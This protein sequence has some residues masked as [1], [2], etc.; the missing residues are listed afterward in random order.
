MSLTGDWTIYPF[1]NKTSKPI[2]FQTKTISLTKGG[3]VRRSWKSWSL[4]VNAANVALT[5]K[6]KN[7]NYSFIYHFLHACLKC[8]TFHIS[9]TYWPRRLASINQTY[10]GSN[11]FW[12]SDKESPLIRQLFLPDNF[13]LLM[14]WMNSARHK[15]AWW[16]LSGVSK[17]QEFLETNI[18][19]S[20]LESWQQTVS[21]IPWA[22]LSAS[23]AVI[24]SSPKS[25]LTNKKHLYLFIYWFAKR[26][27]KL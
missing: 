10:N 16:K 15:F 11:S 25:L 18:K 23:N 22:S 5:P 4:G 13:L 7:K 14:I 20:F 2:L 1:L 21:C 3:S 19:A 24:G 6:N 27:V 17:S 12:L 9:V 26:Q 8:R